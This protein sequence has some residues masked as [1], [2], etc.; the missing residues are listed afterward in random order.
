[1]KNKLFWFVTFIAF[2]TLSGCLDGGGGGGSS[3]SGTSGTSSSDDSNV[4]LNLDFSTMF[5]GDENMVN[6]NLNVSN[7]DLSV[8][9]SVIEPSGFPISFATETFSGTLVLLNDSDDS[10]AYTFPI[11]AKMDSSW[12][13]NLQQSITV[14]P[15]AYKFNIQFQKNS[16]Q[17]LG[18]T[19]A[20]VS[21]GDNTI[22][23]NVNPVIG[24]TLVT[25]TVI[26]SPSFSFNYPASDFNG[27]GDPE[28]DV[29][30]DGSTDA[31]LVLAQFTGSELVYANLDGTHD[32]ELLLRD[33]TTDVAKFSQSNFNFQAGTNYTF[34]LT[35]IFGRVA[36]NLTE[37]GGAAT[38]NFFIPSEVVDEVG[39]DPADL[40]ATFSLNGANNDSTS[41]IL[42][43]VDASGDYTAST[44]ISGIQYDTLTLGLQFEDI[45]GT[46]ETIGTCS[47][48]VTVDVSADS[49]SCAITLI[50]RA[51]ISGRFFQVVAVNVVDATGD[52]VTGAFIWHNDGS[53]DTQWATP[54]GSNAAYADGYVEMTLPVGSYNFRAQYNDGSNDFSSNDVSEDIDAS[55]TGY[56]LLYLNETP[57]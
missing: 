49:G 1:M 8:N 11:T 3:D 31:T 24:D 38:F 25:T 32:I 23:L 39:G 45:S 52:A 37:S 57:I 26:E 55:N 5:L 43:L 44:I 48:D 34:D 7:I 9:D 13:A 17:Y 35:A 21:G 53:G 40:R 20:T 47:F 30:V 28:M 42:S 19:T 33:G 4:I 46:P 22:A 51:E 12:D 18:T 36:I 6:A 27:L 41:D 56:L 14:K 29:I 16:Y 10:T 50:R 54:T 2:V 15:G